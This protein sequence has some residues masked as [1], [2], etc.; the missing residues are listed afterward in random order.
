[1]PA[2]VIKAVVDYFGFIPDEKIYKNAGKLPP[3]LV[4]HNEKDKVVPIDMSKELLAALTA[5]SVEQGHKFYDNGDPERLYHPFTPGGKADVN[6]R[7][8]TV[9]WLKTHLK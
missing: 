9:N 4:F 6:S 3:T 1:M 5:E 2:G 7:S 8:Q